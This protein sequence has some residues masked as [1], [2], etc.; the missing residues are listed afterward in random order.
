MR[1]DTILSSKNPI[2]ELEQSKEQDK[3]RVKKLPLAVFLIALVGVTLSMW[4]ASWD[5]TSHLLR[6]PE[7]F[8][9]PSHTILYL[10][11]GISL[12][13]AILSLTVFAAKKQARKEP[14]AFGMKIIIAGAIMQIIAGPSDFYWHELFGI[15]GLLSPTHITLALGIMI[16]SIGSIIGFAR[17]N[18]RT[19]EQNIFLKIIMPIAFGVFWFSTM[20]MV[21][22]FVLPIS[23]G[24]THNF[25]PDQYVA[26]TLSFVALPFI[27][28]IIFWSSFKTLN[29]FGSASASALVF[30]IMNITSNI[31]T[32]E[33]LLFYLPWFVAPMAS[34]VMAEYILYKK[35]K[36]KLIQN[37]SEK[38]AGAVMGSM[39]F[40]FSFPMLSMTFLQPYLFNDVFSYDILHTSSNSV[41]EFWSLS[42]IPGAIVGM[43]GM[44]FA[45]RKLNH[46]SNNNTIIGSSKV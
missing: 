40:M 2:R 6:T 32:S 43:L 19:K 23:E 16:V 36:F 44:I 20:W 17:I 39:F 13:S 31:F 42:I 7:T 46:I 1:D 12:I 45:S 9:T 14:Y 4:G 41:L 3:I 35:F 5:I 29:S 27:F 15:D 11:V 28:S 22:F 25:N 33:N 37:H 18:S 34:A 21:F 26:M 38:F 8:F 24:D 10:G 30:I